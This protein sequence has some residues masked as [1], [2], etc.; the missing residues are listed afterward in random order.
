MINCYKIIGKFYDP[1]SLSYRIVTEH[2][3]QV[4]QMALEVA[5]IVPDLKPD[6]NFIREAGLLH[7]IGIFLTDAPLIGCL[8]KYQYICHGYKGREILDD[9]GLPVHALVCENHVGVG[10]TAKEIKSCQ[11][12][13]PERDMVPVSIEEQIICYADKF[14]SKG[15]KLQS[16]KK[17]INEVL[18]TLKHYGDDKVEIF[19]KWSKIFGN[20]G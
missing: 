6:V 3:K 18:H 13:L 2:G 10:I 16:K 12:P 8:G 4:A 19:L 20:I 9:L 7:D 5:A 15:S 17:T 1:D 14:F 11:L